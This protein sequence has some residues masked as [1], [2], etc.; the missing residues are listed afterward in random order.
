MLA[1][2]D[3]KVVVGALQMAD[4]LMRKLPD[5][6]TQHFQKQGVTFQIK[7]LATESTKE[8]KRETK[9]ETSGGTDTTDRGK[10]VVSL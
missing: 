8:A 6:F 4:I 9:G 2:Q 1:S 7:R 3:H 10:V 5:T